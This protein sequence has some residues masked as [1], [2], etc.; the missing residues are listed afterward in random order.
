[1]NTRICTALVLGLLATAAQAQN[2]TQIY[3]MPKEQS[4]ELG[5]ARPSTPTRRR[6][7]VR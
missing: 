2:S 7:W 5:T 4:I 3:Q 1:M 6:R